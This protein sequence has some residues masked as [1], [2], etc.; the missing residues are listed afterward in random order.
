MDQGRQWFKNNAWKFNDE[1]GLKLMAASLEDYL[2]IISRKHNIPR[3]NIAVL[4]FSQGA[5]TTLYAL[6]SLSAPPSAVIALSGGLTVEP[7]IDEAKPTTPI[8]FI[9]GLAD[10]VWP[11]DVTVKAEAFYRKH[12]YPTQIELLPELP[13]GIDARVLAHVTL[14][15]GEIWHGSA[16]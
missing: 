15:L 7:I 2:T 4:G 6:P 12:G 13:H 9:H 16:I 14:F 11:A 10:D 8:L 1:P 3:T 5:M